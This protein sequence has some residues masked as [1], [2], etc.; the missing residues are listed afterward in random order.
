MKRN[1]P[2]FFHYVIPEYYPEYGGIQKSLKRI[3]VSI[4]NFFPE[5]YSNIYVLDTK[6]KNYGNVFYLCNEKNELAK[7]FLTDTNASRV[8]KNLSRMNFFLLRNRISAVIQSYPYARHIIISFYAS[9][10]GFYAQ[11]VAHTF[12]LLHITSVR[13]SDFYVNFL[14]HTSFASTEFVVQRADFIVTT[15]TFQKNLLS[16]L[17]PIVKNKIQTIHNAN[18][19]L[20]SVYRNYVEKDKWQPI[21]IIADC[22]FS[23]KK[24]T[25]FILNSFKY[26]IFNG[27]KIELKIAGEIESKTKEYWYSLIEKYSKQYIKSFEYIGFVDDIQA[28]M[29][30]GDIFVSASLSE[31]CS[32]SRIQALCT[33]IPIVSTGDGAIVDYEINRENVRI[34]PPGNQE[35]FTQAIEDLIIQIQNG[36]IF[37]SEDE[38]RKRLDYFS[39]KREQKE[40]TSIIIQL[41]NYEG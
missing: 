17:Y 33:G 32:N 20:P 25:E 36:G 12:E 2:I 28:F 13:G 16:D 39:I 4:E 3:S 7:S 41:L 5:S 34:V 1:E 21:R 27:Y 37:V 22:G 31:G 14:N 19:D 29:Q 23:Y 24:G 6:A 11:L 8:Q 26:L 40:W 38:I 18:E 15:N 30:E 10:A 35:L 9:H